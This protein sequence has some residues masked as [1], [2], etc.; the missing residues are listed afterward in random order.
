MDACCFIA[1]ISNEAGRGETCYRIFKDAADGK[2]EIVT[3]FI[4]VVEVTKESPLAASGEA[5]TSAKID[6]FFLNPYIRLVAV[7]RLIAEKARDIRRA[8]ADLRNFDAVHLATAIVAR[9]AAFYTYDA[10]LLRRDGKIEALKIEEP[11]W[12]G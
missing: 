8:H 9:V 10:Q 11:V 4:T 7:E 12:E 3:S 6:R 1:F 5:Y 2:L